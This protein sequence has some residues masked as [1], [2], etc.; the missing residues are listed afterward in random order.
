MRRS[1]REERSGGVSI[2]LFSVSCAAPQP[3]LKHVGTFFRYRLSGMSLHCGSPPSPG[4]QSYYRFGSAVQDRVK[5]PQRLVF[6]LAVRET[7]SVRRRERGLFSRMAGNQC[8]RSRLSGCP[9]FVFGIWEARKST[10]CNPCVNPGFQGE[11]GPPGPPLGHAIHRQPVEFGQADGRC[12][13][14]IQIIR[15]A[16]LPVYTVTLGGTCAMLAPTFLRASWKRTVWRGVD[17]IRHQLPPT[18][19]YD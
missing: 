18:H 10:T 15:N 17:T 3:G 9:L 19:S 11:N 12:H 6:W 1:L 16:F 13:I 8:R 14:P 2:P 5:P 7:E 4:Q